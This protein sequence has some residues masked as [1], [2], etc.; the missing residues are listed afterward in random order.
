M[1]GTGYDRLMQSCPEIP[2]V[3]VTHV[4]FCNLLLSDILSLPSSKE[5]GSHADRMKIQTG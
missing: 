3:I 2:K 1:N 5:E 4:D